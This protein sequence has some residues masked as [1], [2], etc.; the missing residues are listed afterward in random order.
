MARNPHN[1]RWQR[2]LD[3]VAE[4]IESASAEEVLE[5]ARL[6]NRDPAQ[7][8]AHVRRV[9][10]EAVR[11]H[12]QQELARAREG[13]ERDVAALN[14]QE[15]DLP[16]DPEILRSWLAAVFQQYPTLTLQNRDFNE[17]TNEDI[18]AHLRKLAMFGLLKDVKFPSGYD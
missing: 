15:I 9:L 11:A 14:E 18:E 8:A 4:Y 12:Q 1:Q 16:D 5:D 2:I 13:Y 6:G 10:K 17:L 7:I 3:G